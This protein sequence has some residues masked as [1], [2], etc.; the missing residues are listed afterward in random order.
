MRGLFVGRFQPF[1]NGHL[2][3]IETIIKDNEDLEALFIVIG[4]SRQSHTPRN[5]FTAGERWVMVHDNIMHSPVLMKAEMKGNT[6]FDVQIFQIPD[7]G[8]GTVWRQEV[9]DHLPRF[10][11]VFDNISETSRL[12][13]ELGYEIRGYD[14]IG[15]T[16]GERWLSGTSVRKSMMLNY[17]AGKQYVEIEHIWSEMIPERTMI[18]LLKIDGINRVREINGLK[19]AL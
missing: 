2:H 3:A 16:L 14:M 10:D 7:A 18:T 12:F 5:P 19:P 6:K 9:I 4:S 17:E 8:N 11:V 13:R 15:I 1:H